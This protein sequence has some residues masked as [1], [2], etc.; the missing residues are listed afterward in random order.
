MGLAWRF[1]DDWWVQGRS[2][3]QRELLDAESMSCAA[4]S[5]AANCAERVPPGKGQKYQLG[6]AIEPDLV[7]S[8]EVSRDQ[9]R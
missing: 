9:T 4:T 7:G 5:F 8:C 6:G 1:R 3:D 2:D